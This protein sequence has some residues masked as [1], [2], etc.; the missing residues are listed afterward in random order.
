MNSRWRS[1]PVT[2]TEI[3]RLPPR[4][5]T[6]RWGGET[7]QEAIAMALDYVLITSWNKWYEGSE[8]EPS[9][10]YNSWILDE[11]VAFSRDCLARNR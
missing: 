1:S 8:V 5:V 11:T 4:P 10:E 9:L 6:D 7:W 2:T 3:G